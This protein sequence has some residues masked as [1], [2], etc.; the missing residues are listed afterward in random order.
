[1]KRLLLQ[2]SISGMLKRQYTF[3]DK[4]LNNQSAS[5]SA[6]NCQD[7]E[8]ANQPPASVAAM[9]I[10]ILPFCLIDEQSICFTDAFAQVHSASL[11][12]MSS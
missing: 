8:Q 6:V 9:A 7:S 5:A 11:Q 1:V 12:L 10:V 3:A 2:H 4:M